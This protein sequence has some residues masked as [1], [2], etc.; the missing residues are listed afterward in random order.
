MNHTY[1]LQKYES[2]FRLLMA[3]DDRESQAARL[4][5]RPISPGAWVYEKELDR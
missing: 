2:L 1:S 5:Y 3:C 4:A